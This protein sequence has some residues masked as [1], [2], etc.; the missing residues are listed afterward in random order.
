[1][2]LLEFREPGDHQDCENDS[3]KPLE[4]VL[5]EFDKAHIPPYV[6]LS[7][8]W[9]PVEDEVSFRD[10]TQ[11][12]PQH[13][14]ARQKQGYSKIE[15]CC[16]Q[17]LRDKIGHAWV[18]TC[19]IDKNSSAELSEA[20]NSMFDWYGRASICYVYLGDVESSREKNG[21]AEKEDCFAK[22]SS[23][24]ASR[25]FTRGW[26]LQEMIAPVDVR[27][28]SKDWVEIGRKR[29]MTGLL[30]EITK[31][32][33]DILVH[34]HALKNVHVSQKMYWA[35]GRETTREEDR[36]Y[37]LLGLFGINM[38]II[39]GE[40]SH[41][42]AR[43][44]QE[45]IQSSFDHTIFAWQLRS[46]LSGL[47]AQSPNDFASSA[48]VRPMSQR[49]YDT[50]FGFSKIDYSVTNLGVYVRL[51]RRRI[52]SH[53]CLY[54][55]F[56]ACCCGSRTTPIFLYLRRNSEGA[57]GRK[58][59]QYFRTRKVNRSIGDGI[60]I[61]SYD[62]NLFKSQ[63]KIW[64]AAPEEPLARR[65]RP[66]LPDELAVPLQSDELQRLRLYQIR[67]YF[68]GELMIVCPL[69]DF[70]GESDLTIET[71]EGLIT[72]TKIKLRFNCVVWLLLTVIDNQLV[73]HI[74]HE[75]NL[76]LDEQGFD[77][78][79]EIR[80]CKAFYDRCVALRKS[81]HTEIVWRPSR[82]MNKD[83]PLGITGKASDIIQIR[84]ES[85]PDTLHDRNVF[86]VWLRLETN[87]DSGGKVMRNPEPWQKPLSDLLKSCQPLFESTSDDEI[88]SK[89]AATSASVSTF[90]SKSVPILAGAVFSGH[91]SID[92]GTNS[93]ISNQ[94]SEIVKREERF[95]TGHAN[96]KQLNYTNG[97]GDGVI[98]GT[99]YGGSE[100]DSYGN[101]LSRS[102][103]RLPA[104]RRRYGDEA[105][106][107][108]D[109]LKQMHRGVVTFFANT[110]PSGMSDS[111]ADADADADAD[112]QENG[113]FFYYDCPCF[114]DGFT[115]GYYRA[116]Y[117]VDKP[118]LIGQ[119][120][121][122]YIHAYS[123]GFAN[124]FRDVFLFSTMTALG[125]HQELVEEKCRCAG[126]YAK[127][128]AVGYLAGNAAGRAKRFS[129]Y[130]G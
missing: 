8:R 35:S 128:F 79:H 60:N 66:L 12:S 69:G 124:S 44:Q 101:L 78:T 98:E 75:V 82:I 111:Y 2:Y 62:R 121:Q 116:L 117:W 94:T 102:D 83:I 11:D 122:V 89:V 30:R 54:I 86:A 21:R 118:L 15:Q 52:K 43:L 90:T 55:V 34:P 18:D 25:W 53:K 126:V 38:P 32:S 14:R 17:A 46:N 3:T 67:L 13:G 61:S 36:A 65:I 103:F 130:R 106:G 88:S 77:T 95:A 107:L 59:G 99:K 64:V 81:P 19:C 123:L 4:I 72:I 92:L 58:S 109:D 41:A 63:T 71:L 127:G 84:Q 110:G 115:D 27:F 76:T 40:G 47:L 113:E 91:L 74:E 49:E 51:P 93:L 73:S 80:S 26:T 100:G 7:H 57:S 105:T 10:M 42:F 112:M 45:I 87:L 114:N 9:G 119:Y 22:N 33:E 85:F 68:Q 20:I 56:L 6:I 5:R 96:I 120:P 39:Y 129:G 29:E 104:G 37:S 50:T 24:R 108:Q 125:R 16:R 31:V 23:F 1:M 48:K 97:Y 28:H 70:A